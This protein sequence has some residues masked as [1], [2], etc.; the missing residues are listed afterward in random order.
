M[1]RRFFDHVVVVQDQRQLVGLGL[2][3]VDQRGD[4]AMARQ[5]RWSGQEAKELLAETFA[6]AVQG[7]DHIPPEA[8]RVVVV[9]VQRQPGTGSLAS[10]AS[11]PAGW[12]C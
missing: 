7:R 9:E 10:A 6:G 5:R 4:Q 12:S 1:Y 3:L 2:E 8:G 11:R